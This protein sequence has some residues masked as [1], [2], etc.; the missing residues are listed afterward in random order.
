MVSVTPTE[1]R[2]CE[3]ATST[4]PMNKARAEMPIIEIRFS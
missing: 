1:T 3:F 4:L 2:V